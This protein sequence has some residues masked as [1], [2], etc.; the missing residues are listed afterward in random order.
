MRII[1]LYYFRGWKR[2][3][4]REFWTS[5]VLTVAMCVVAY[6]LAAVLQLYPK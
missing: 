3:E 2:K 6:I 4:K 5:L 1:D